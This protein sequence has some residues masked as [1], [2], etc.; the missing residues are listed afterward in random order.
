MG[1]LIGADDLHVILA[2]VVRVIVVTAIWIEARW[3]SGVQSRIDK[4]IGISRAIVSWTMIAIRCLMIMR[5]EAPVTVRMVRHFARVNCLTEIVG[6]V[7]VAVVVVEVVMV[8]ATETLGHG[9]R[10]P[11]ATTCV[12]QVAMM[13]VNQVAVMDVNLAAMMCE[14]QAA[15]MCGNLVAMMAVNPVDF[16]VV[17]GLKATEAGT[18]GLVVV[19]EETMAIAGVVVAGMTGAGMMAVVV[20]VVKVDHL[21]VAG[22]WDADGISEARDAAERF[23]RPVKSLRAHLMASSN[24]TH[25]DTVFSATQRETT[26]RK[27]PTRLFQVHW[28]RNT[29]CDKVS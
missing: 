15:V 5:A 10:K 14:S 29:S 17:A 28:L 27:T 21:V 16:R 23:S 18:M 20:D 9:D 26:L 6:L 8:L 25:V 22:I 13:C 1:L 4:L 7:A 2:E 19:M 24:F 12:N 3:Q 11:V